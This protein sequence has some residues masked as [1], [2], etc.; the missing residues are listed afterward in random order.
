MPSRDVAIYAPFAGDI[1]DARRGRAGGAERQ[2]VLL[3]RAL[4]ARGMRTGHIV[5]PVAEPVQT[6]APEPDLVTRPW[7]RLSSRGRL[8]EPAVIWQA[9]AKANAAVYVFRGATAA[10]G[11]GAAFCRATG[12]KLVFA[13]ANNSDFTLLTLRD[14]PSRARPYE[15]GLRR[16]DAI[17]VQSADQITLAAEAF[18]GTVPAVEIPSFVEE[19]PPTPHAAEA[20]LW[21]ARLVDYKRP[22][23]YVELARAVPEA[24][25]WMIAVS[26][27]GD[28]TDELEQELYRRAADVPNLE[29]LEPRN[30][31][32]VQELVDRSVAVV[33]TSVTEGM[34]N[35]WLEGW[36]RGVPALSLE[37]DA[38]ERVAQAGLG[39]TAKGSWE[40]FVAGART[41]WEQRADRGGYGDAVRRYIHETHGSQAVGARWAGVLEDVRRA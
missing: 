28:T 2:T 17:V 18:P 22:L 27:I 36:A 15:W 41:L 9:M 40:D 21:V 12:R 6:G 11:P 3:A 30:H 31:A 38:D 1:Y 7:P 32:G 29:L 4:A 25:F 10:L 5:H 24:R 8:L 35:V 33:N 23:E 20:F 26:T 19:A 34:P 14:L 39:I 13:G 16:S 37:F